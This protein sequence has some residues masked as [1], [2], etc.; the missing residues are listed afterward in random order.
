MKRSKKI[1]SVAVLLAIVLSLLPAGVAFADDV[2]TEAQINPAGSPPIVSYK[3]EVPDADSSTAGVQYDSDDGA[4]G[5]PGAQIA[6]N[7]EDLPEVQQIAYWW[8]GTDNN[9]I[10]DIIDAFIR[11]YHPDGSL[12]YQRHANG[13]QPCS[14]LGSATTPNTPLYAAVRSGQ[15]TVAQTQDILE[16]CGKNVLLPFM[17]VDEIS[18][19]QPA[20]DYTV[21]ASLVDQAGNVTHLQ[22][23]MQILPVI[24]LEIDFASVNFGEILP[25][26]NKWV[27]GDMVFGAGTLPSVKNTGN[28]NMYLSLRY[29]RML[30]DALK[31]VIDVFDAKLNAQTY[32]PIPAGTTV[33]FNDEPLGSNEVGQLDLSIHPGSVPADTY[34]GRLYLSGSMGCN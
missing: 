9:G 19:H 3:F 4:L 8:F 32:D 14:A 6:P 18:K 24:G 15:L 2:P 16:N 26:T 22:N 30:G 27:R 10:G 20:G 23:T 29:D 21:Y 5:Q 12:K 11:V 1:S 17:W 31:K 33:C 13:R 7:L 34:R 25:N 28:T